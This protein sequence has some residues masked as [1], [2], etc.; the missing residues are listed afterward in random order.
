MKLCFHNNQARF[1][2]ISSNRNKRRVRKVEKKSLNYK[3]IGLGQK[4][5]LAPDEFDIADKNLRKKFLKFLEEL[6]ECIGVRRYSCRID[7]KS[8]TKMIASAALL[9]AAELYRLK[10]FTNGSVLIKCIRP[11]SKKIDQVLQQIGIYEL[12]GQK[13]SITLDHDDVIHWR[14]AR[15]SE[16]NGEKYEQILG[17]YDGDISENLQEGLYVGLTEAMA[18]SHDHAYLKVRN[19]GLSFDDKEK[20]W[21]MFSQEKDNKLSVVFCDLGVG[22]PETLPITQKNL[23]ESLVERFGGVLKDDAAIKEA[24]TYSKSRTEASYRGKGLAQITKLIHTFGSKS[25]LFIYSNRG[26]FMKLDGKVSTMNYKT[27]I[28]GTLICWQVPLVKGVD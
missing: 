17:H 26:L 23:Y 16:V 15:G 9:F 20:Q 21:W 7:M 22:I 24:V 3:A 1:G 13:Q 27:S 12:L 5:V 8:T 11:R 2:R 14:F 18:N 25:N 6:R 28:M 19:D 10:S 4:V